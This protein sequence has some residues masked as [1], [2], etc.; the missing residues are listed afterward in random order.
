MQPPPAPHDHHRF[1][2][3][4]ISRAVSLVCEIGGRR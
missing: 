2:A 4:T 1:L 3:E